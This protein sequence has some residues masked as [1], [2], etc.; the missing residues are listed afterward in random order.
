M[1]MSQR[2]A[3]GATLLDEKRP[4]WASLI[5]VDVLDL[6]SGYHCILGQLYKR[7]YVMGI[8]DL[9]CDERGDQAKNGFDLSH[10]EYLSDHEDAM[11]D[12]L[13]AAWHE[14]INKRVSD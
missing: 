7:D 6:A 10:E 8:H 12:D 5:N 4:G 2:A 11:W 1:E 9:G 3:N 13:N 14:E